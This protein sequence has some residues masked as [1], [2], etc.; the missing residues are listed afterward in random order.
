MMCLFGFIPAEKIKLSKQ[1]RK[2]KSFLN[3][4]VWFVGGSSQQK[5]KKQR[6]L[7]RAFLIKVSSATLIIRSCVCSHLI[8]IVE[9]LQWTPAALSW[10]AARLHSK[11]YGYREKQQLHYSTKPPFIK[12]ILFISGLCYHL[13]HLPSFHTTIVRLCSLCVSFD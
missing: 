5:S 7:F 12:R 11:F 10:S 1:K 13:C 9:G 8:S 4:S 3:W 6:N 2:K